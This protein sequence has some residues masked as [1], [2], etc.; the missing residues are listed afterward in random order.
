M[1]DMDPLKLLKPN[2]FD[3]AAKHLYAR[4]REEKYT[5]DFGEKVYRMHLRYWNNFKELNDNSKNSYA[6]FLSKFDDIL[7][8]IKIQGFNS[9][10]GSLPLYDNCLIN[11]G[12]RLAASILYN[13]EIKT[14]EGIE[15]EGQLDCS[16]SMFLAKGLPQIYIDAMAEEYTRMAQN[17]LFIT[18][19][20]SA[21][22]DADKMAV[23]LSL[24]AKYC[25]IVYFKKIKWK[26]NAGLNLVRQIYLGEEWGLTWAEKYQGFARKAELCFTTRAPIYTL[27]IQPKELVNMIN[28]KEEIR[29]IFNI[30]KHSCHI[31]DTHAETVRLSRIYYNENSMHYINNSI[32]SYYPDF[33]RR[34][35]IYEDYMKRNNLNTESYCITASSVLTIY[36][37]LD[38]NDLDYLHFNADTINANEINTHNKEISNYCHSIS[39]IMFDPQNYFWYNN[40]KVASLRT[41]M[42]L[43]A[44][45]GEAK[46]FNHLK[47]L[48]TLT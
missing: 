41:I 3:V 1:P 38:S 19:F 7:D 6:D 23:A 48:K 39:E 9:S 13:K 44:A 26:N 24:I 43:K 36:G 10:L 11:G 12:H 30:G 32:E 46:D 45:R 37:V 4:Y 35:Q 21:T 31:N 2:R 5:A 47:V 22:Y 18:L 34:F 25:D 8:S 14:H 28:L 40:M 42:K 16:S 15:S 20:P 29:K 27:L 33:E 17:S